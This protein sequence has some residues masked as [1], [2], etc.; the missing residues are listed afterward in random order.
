[1]KATLKKVASLRLWLIYAIFRAYL[2]R[3]VGLRCAA[4]LHFNITLTSFLYI[5]PCWVRWVHYAPNA[6]IPSKFV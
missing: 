6:V 5:A 1:M 2:I 3:S 4:Y